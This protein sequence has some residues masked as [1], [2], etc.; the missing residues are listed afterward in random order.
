MILQCFQAALAFA[1]PGTLERG[2]VALFGS[3]L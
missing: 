2:L 1:S 3:L